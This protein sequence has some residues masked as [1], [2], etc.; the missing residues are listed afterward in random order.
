MKNQEYWKG[1]REQNSKALKQSYYDKKYN[2]SDT[3]V[4]VR[5]S[6]IMLD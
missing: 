1:E 2:N 6:F 5:Y 3:M 4:T